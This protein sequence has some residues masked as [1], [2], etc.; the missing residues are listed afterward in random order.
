MHASRSLAD[1]STRNRR[2][3]VISGAVAAL[4]FT[5]VVPASAQKKAAKS[6]AKSSTASLA[7]AKTQAQDFRTLGMPDDWNNFGRFFQSVCD[8][9]QLGC[10]GEGEGP[11]R[12]D[13]DMS[14][15]EE[16]AAFKTEKDNPAVCADIGIA[17]GQV[18]EAE[19]VTINYLPAAAAKLPA[20]YKAAKGGW[21]ASAVGAISIVVN[22]DVVKNP[23]RSFADLLKDE[24]KGKVSISNPTTSG[25]GQ[26]MVLASAAALGNGKLDLDGAFKYW[27]E[28]KQKGQ[29]N[30][31]SYSN[32]ALEKGE[33]PIT[34]RYDYVG[35]LAA[36]GI[37]DKAGKKIIEVIVPSDG[38]VWAPSATMCNK[39]SD[40]AEL[41]KLVLDHTLTD[42][43][44]LVF[45]EYGARPVRYVLGDLKVPD[46]L[47]KKWLPDAAYAKVVPI[48]GN[49][50]PNPGTIAERW[51]K[52]VL[53]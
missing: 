53:S 27:K 1:R 33:T 16:I 4:A 34:L 35:A 41:A 50:W 15:A 30:P 10:R 22:T 14:S 9:Y 20:P 38:G 39:N 13:T 45:A 12:K 11:N 40:K 19:G 8:S 32:A 36:A 6:S 3:L 23:P 48:P 26:M 49:S 7:K 42:Q 43:G 44:Q 5:Q 2:T 21:V 29:L 51:E 28:M 24:Y 52:E 31:A 37:N 46:V 25:T 17:F 47:K 18:A